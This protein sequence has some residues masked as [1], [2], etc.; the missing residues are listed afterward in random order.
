M[1]EVWDELA[2]EICEPQE[3][4]NAFDGG[5]GFLVANGG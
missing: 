1:R 3:G 5:R 2:I 4:V